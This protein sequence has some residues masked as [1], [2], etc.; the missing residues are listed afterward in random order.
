MAD[1]YARRYLAKVKRA[2]PWDHR[3]SDRVKHAAALMED[4]LAEAPSAGEQ[5]LLAAFGAPAEFAAEMAGASEI[6]RA[7]KQRKALLWCAI[8]AVLLTL[9]A[10]AAVF[11]L[12]WRKLRKDLPEDGNFNLI[13][14]AETLTQEEFDEL[15]NDPNMHWEG[16]E[17]P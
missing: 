3:R 4:Y 17:W 13:Y 12:R 2:L 15:M 14:P 1:K 9:V 6:T 11:F 10:V 5:D 16:T 7:K 8:G